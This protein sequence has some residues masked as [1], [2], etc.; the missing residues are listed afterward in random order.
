MLKPIA[1]RAGNQGLPFGSAVARVVWT[2]TG[3][4]DP[5]EVLLTQIMSSCCIALSYALDDIAYI[6]EYAFSIVPED[7]EGA[8]ARMDPGHP[9]SL[10]QALFCIEQVLTVL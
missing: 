10:D 1:I 9:R 6:D 4:V 7:S 8:G 2:T 3:G 5:I